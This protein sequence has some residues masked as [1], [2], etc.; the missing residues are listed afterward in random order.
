[1][2]IKS[3]ITAALAA[4]SVS[5][6]GPNANAQMACQFGVYDDTPSE[7]T[8]WIERPGYRFQVPDNYTA[9]LMNNGDVAVVDPDTAQHMA[10]MQRLNLGTSYT[11]LTVSKEPARINEDGWPY[12]LPNFEWM[13]LLQNIEYGETD[14]GQALAAIIWESAMNGVMNS[15]LMN[16]NEG[17]LVHV[18]SPIYD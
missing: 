8:R 14:E 12:S 3:I 18:S 11:Y 13:P 9:Q 10:C 1:M 5:A 7:K 17:G 16:L 2:K 15:G 6:I 4:L